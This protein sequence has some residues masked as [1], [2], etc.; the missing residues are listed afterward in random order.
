MEGKCRASQGRTRAVS[1]KAP[2]SPHPRP[3][4]RQWQRKKLSFQRKIKQASEPG[5][6]GFHEAGGLGGGTD[7]LQAQ[8]PVG[9]SETPGR[10]RSWG[11][12][13]ETVVSP[14]DETPLPQVTDEE[15]EAARQLPMPPRLVLSGVPGWR[16]PSL[17]W[18]KGM[19]PERE[20]L[21]P[22]RPASGAEP[23]RGSGNRSAVLTCP[24]GPHPTSY[25][26]LPVSVFSAS[27]T[28]G[29]GPRPVP[30]PTP[31]RSQERGAR[32]W[33]LP[34]EAGPRGRWGN[35]FP[36]VGT[37]L[38]RPGP[39]S[40]PKL[41]LDTGPSGGRGHSQGRGQ[42]RA[43]L[44]STSGNQGQAGAGLPG[45]SLLRLPCLG[46]GPLGG[47]LWARAA[48][49]SVEGLGERGWLAPCRPLAGSTRC[50]Q[51]LGG[52]EVG[53]QVVG[54]WGSSVLQDCRGGS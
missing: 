6:A 37:S 44:S 27:K 49:N 36:G 13:R 54:T 22:P 17:P 48:L 41:L 32:G 46:C 21:G 30:A 8:I 52:E 43:S 14:A 15:T 12:R 2:L 31:H 18:E 5:L 3:S 23:S 50:P 28:G 47:S 4:A 45:R 20:G 16:G 51:A 1:T 24:P 33:A 25:L 26:K 29:W 19:I 38:D 10:Q 39:P 7:P 34:R 11:Q 40:A 53:A 35:V 42:P 9:D